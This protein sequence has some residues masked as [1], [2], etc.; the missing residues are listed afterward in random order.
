MPLEFQVTR[1]QENQDLEFAKHLL[2]FPFVAIY[3]QLV[4]CSTQSSPNS[5]RRAAAA[6]GYWFSAIL[7]FDTITDVLVCRSCRH[8]RVAKDVQQKSRWLLICVGL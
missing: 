3:L 5:L 4:A 7:D 8:G 1:G 2:A 6:N